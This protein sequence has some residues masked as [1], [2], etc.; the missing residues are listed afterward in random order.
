[1]NKL[2]RYNEII[3]EENLN[4]AEKVTYL[5][6]LKVSK[7][8]EVAI[9]LDELAVYLGKTKRAVANAIKALEEKEF[10]KIEKIRSQNGISNQNN[11]ILK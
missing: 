3:T 10:I 8:N 2:S 9:T 4:T 11:Y 5:I 1:M 6:L 7:E